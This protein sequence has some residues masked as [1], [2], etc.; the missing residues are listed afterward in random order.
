MGVVNKMVIG[1]LLLGFAGTSMVAAV[2]ADEV[3]EQ[4][5]QGLELYREGEYGGAITE[6]EF[7][8]SDLRKLVAG[9]ISETFP[10]APPGWTAAEASSEQGG[11]GAAMMFGGSGGTMLERKYSQDGGQGR[12]EAT[13]MIDNPMIQGM[14]ALFNNPAIMGAQANTERVRIGRESAMVKWEANRS[15]AEATLLLDG[16][17]LIQ[18]NGQNL[19]SPDVAVDLLRAWDLNAVRA[20]AGR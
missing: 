1:S 10:D 19:D 8:I 2:H 3:L 16:R 5:E 18:V 15:R 4:I 9:Q 6:L 13:L 20:Q 17:I 12:M 7:A 14:A 11:G